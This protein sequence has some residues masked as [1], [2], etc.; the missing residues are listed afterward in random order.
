VRYSS[1]PLPPYRFVPGRSAHP[2]VGHSHGGLE[3]G[4]A[5][6]EATRWRESATYLYAIDL[7]NLAYWW[8]CHEVLESFWRLAERG[9]HEARLLQGV[10]QLAAANLKRFMGEEPVAQSLAARGLTKLEGLASPLLGVDVPALRADAGA[11]FAGA[12]E[13]AAV[14]RLAGLPA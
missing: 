4:Q 10:I 9:S 14:I 2:Q 1:A 6:L 3:A 8:E 11:Y 5:P 13:L 7:Y 12:R